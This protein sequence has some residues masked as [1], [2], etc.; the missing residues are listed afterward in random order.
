MASAYVESKALVKLAGNHSNPTL[1]LRL[2][3]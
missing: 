3:Q 1:K 2:T